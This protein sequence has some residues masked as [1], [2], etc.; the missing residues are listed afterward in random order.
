MQT[1]EPKAA[2]ATKVRVFNLAKELKLEATDV[3]EFCKELGFTAVKNQLNGL[4]PEQVDAL[5]ERAK[6]GLPKTHVTAAT[7]VVTPPK[8][9]IP[10]P[11]ALAGA[12]KVRTIPPP[13]SAIPKPP[14]APV[15][16]PEPEPEFESSPH[17]SEMSEV[18]TSSPMT[19]TPEIEPQGPVA[20]NLA[21][22]AGGATKRPTNL[23]AR[24][25]LKPAKPLA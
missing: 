1:K 15:H 22:I 23:G 11:A 25:T 16:I 24:T 6:K 5:R 7:A 17:P 12:S 10:S 9:A 13:K 14:P 21:A 19:S 20:P 3:I 2:K 4:E 18:E 8:A